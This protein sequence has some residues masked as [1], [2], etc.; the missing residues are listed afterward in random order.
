MENL[1]NPWEFNQ[2]LYSL[3]KAEQFLFLKHHLPGRS[4]RIP[5]H[6]EI[7]FT[8]TGHLLFASADSEGI[9]VLLWGVTAQG[10]KFTGPRP[11]IT[12]HG[13]DVRGRWLRLYSFPA[14]T[15]EFSFSL[16]NSKGEE[17]YM[18]EGHTYITEKH[19]AR[20]IKNYTL[21]KKS[22]LV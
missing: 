3:K 13:A 19:A 18:L 2:Y 5:P 11:A 15:E 17:I 10:W 22:C 14:D 16:S 8:C 1:K 12:A 4:F 20:N 6:E 9:I 21:Q 7:L